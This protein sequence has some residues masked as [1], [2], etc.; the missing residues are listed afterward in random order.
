M[1]KALLLS[2]A[3]TFSALQNFATNVSG[4]ISNSTTW[5]K[6]NSPYIVTGDI[7]VDTN[8]VLTIEPGVTIKVD[9]NYAI[10]VDGIINAAGTDTDNILF[11]SNKSNPAMG[12]WKGIL[13]RRIITTDTLVLIIATCNMQIKQSQSMLR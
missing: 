10:Y 4:I 11:T 9:G 5:T 7:D 2:A 1:K 6:A 3:L 8:A 12:D 13:V